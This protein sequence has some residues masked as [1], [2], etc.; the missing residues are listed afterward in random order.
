MVLPDRLLTLWEGGHPYCI[1]WK[2]LETL[3]MK[4][5]GNLENHQSYSAHP[6]RD[7]ITGNIY[8]L[9]VTPQYL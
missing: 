9:G 8:N 5:L 1:N 7:N 4:N 2:T 3:G 6:K